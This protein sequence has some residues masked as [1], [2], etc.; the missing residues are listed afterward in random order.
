MVASSF[1][2]LAIV[3]V[4]IWLAIVLVGWALFYALSVLY[5]WVWL[6][7]IFI[8]KEQTWKHMESKDTD[9]PDDASKN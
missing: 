3:G 8:R 2:F 9:K 1:I 5:C 7:V 6:V 4:P